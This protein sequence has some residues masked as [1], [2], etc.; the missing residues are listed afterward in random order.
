MEVL[1]IDA[2]GPVTCDAT[3][4]CYILT[5]IDCF[6]RFVEL[7]PVNDTSALLCARALLNHVCRYGTPMTIHSDRGT[8]FVNGIIKE[9][10]DLLQVEHEVSFWPTLRNKMQL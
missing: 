1:N 9:L 8:Q 6:T 4:N 2:I 10:L 3:E 7:Y 5:V